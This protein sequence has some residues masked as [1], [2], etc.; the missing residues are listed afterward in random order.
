[1]SNGNFLLHDDPVPAPCDMGSLCIGC[2]PRNPDGSCPG[3]GFKGTAM[4]LG[5]ERMFTTKSGI[6]FT[7]RELVIV[8][9]REVYRWMPHL[10]GW[11]YRGI[12][13]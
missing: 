13:G 2:T 8:R 12:R 10:G 4:I 5:P 9:R 6:R 11:V 7:D 3:A 1:M